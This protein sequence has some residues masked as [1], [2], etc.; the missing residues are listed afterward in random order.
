MT[1]LGIALLFLYF[2]TLSVADV[3][4]SLWESTD[5]QL[6]D[7]L[8][9]L[10]R[11]SKLAP[12]VD[13]GE[14]ALVLVDISTLDKPRVASLNGDQMFYAASLPKIAILLGAFVLIE[15]GELEPDEQLKR[16]MNRMIRQSDNSAATRVLEHVGR[17]RLLEILQSQKYLL[18]DRKHN[19]GLWVGKDYGPSNAYKRDPINKLSHGATAMQVARFYYL[20]ETNRLVGP[21]LT[22]DMKEMLSD[23]AIKHKFVKGLEEV[24]GTTLY[25]KSGT[26]KQFHADSALVEFS[27]YKYIIAGLARSSHGGKWL[28]SIARPLH[29]IVLEASHPR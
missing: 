4:P 22:I 12:A 7:K 9:E 19:G 24:D 2:T 1:R 21:E 3:Y 5:I 29:D 28:E 26:W 11:N 10:V 17:D 18:Y 27:D 6:Q 23:P 25:R 14:L 8:E 20:L 15:D 13:A 16:D